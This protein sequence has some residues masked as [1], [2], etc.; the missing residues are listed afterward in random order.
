[1]SERIKLEKW[2]G[3]FPS[4]LK[5]I[6][7]LGWKSELEKSQVSRMFKTGVTLMSTHDPTRPTK[8]LKQSD[9]SKPNPWVDPT[10]G[11]LWADILLKWNTC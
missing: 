9:P 11:Q 10:H 8:N 4:E 6:F 7:R 3:K 1:M 5:I 2:I